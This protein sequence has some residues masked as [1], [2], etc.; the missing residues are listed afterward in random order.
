MG[1][2]PFNIT[3]LL[4]LNIIYVFCD[5]KIIIPLKTINNPD[6]SL[7]FIESLLQ[8]QLY[9]EIKLGTPEQ[10]IYLSIS[11]ETADFI[12]ESNLIN[13][14]FYSFNES[15]TYINT[16]KKLSF[17]HE[18]YNLGYV[19][20][21][22]FYFQNEMNNNL[23]T[24]NNV[25]FGC[26]FDLSEEF[27]EKEKKYFIDN[28]KNQISGVIGLQLSKSY[29]STNNLLNSL[30]FVGAINR[31]IWSIIYY[32]NNNE[33]IINLIIGENPFNT[34]DDNPKRVSAYSGNGIDSYWYFLFNDII[35]GN[36]KLNEERI[37]EYS[38][39]IGV[40]IGTDEYKEYINNNFFSKK[41]N[42]CSSHT[43]TINRK[44]YS[45]F[46]CEKLVYINNFEP[47]V[48]THQELSYNFTLDKNDLFIDY[49]DKKYFLCIFLEKEEGGTYY[50]NKHWILGKP[51]V[52]KYNFVFDY[53]S[54]VILF[55]ELINTHGNKDNARIS[56]FAWFF[57]II[58]I[59]LVGVLGIYLILK[60]IFRP[61]RIQANELEDSFNY[62]NQKNDNNKKEVDLSGFYNSKYSKLGIEV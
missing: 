61:K 12:I 13:E 62:N 36:T 24:F 34:E 3:I 37:A 44:T 7:N 10:T 60:L 22:K 23:K 25:T 33:D 46:E 9:A 32:N 58:L 48:F 29:A 14:K 21:D 41:E 11:T 18:R 47:L 28:N 17:Y 43:I 40:I 49:N 56:A 20:K 57:I 5:N 4:L 52:K 35:T 2:K 51:F 39:Q 16:E 54:K 30:S 45:Y 42:M 6:Q 31:N 26:I 55:Y 53:N 38:P 59:I 15:S 1:K 50:S 27:I 8:N 19:F